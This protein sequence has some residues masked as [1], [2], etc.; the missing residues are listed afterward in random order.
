MKILWVEC[1]RLSFLFGIIEGNV[2]PFSGADADSVFNGDDEDTAVADFA[3]LCGF[4]DSLYCLFCVFIAYN[5]RD[6]DTFDGTGVVQYTTVNT[7][8]SGFSDT[9]Y[10]VIRESFDICFEE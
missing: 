3:G 1:C 5:D 4:D 10:I 2:T 6:E 7:G 9:S 8:L